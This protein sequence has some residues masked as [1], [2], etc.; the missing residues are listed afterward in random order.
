MDKSVRIASS[1]TTNNH[2]RQSTEQV[3]LSQHRQDLD[4]QVMV[5]V[6]FDF[7]FQ[8]INRSSGEPSSF[9]SAVQ[10]VKLFLSHDL[11]NGIYCWKTQEGR[12]FGLEMC[13]GGLAYLLLNTVS[14]CDKISI[15]RRKE[16]RPPITSTPHLQQERGIRYLP[17]TSI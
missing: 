3:L 10:L 15:P 16:I 13:G 2:L 9:S 12:E 4:K 7:I 6:T 8:A 5:S 11:E 17:G 1:A 14:D